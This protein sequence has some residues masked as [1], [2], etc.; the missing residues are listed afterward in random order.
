M[1]FCY[2]AA[3]TAYG[4]SQARG[5]V[6]AVAD[7][8]C[9]SHCNASSEPHLHLHHSSQQRQILNP[10]SKARDQTHNLMIPSSD[11]FRF[12][13]MGTPRILNYVKILCGTV[14]TFRIFTSNNFRTSCQYLIFFFPFWAVFAA[15]GISQA[16]D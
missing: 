12:T 9:Q 14:I 5:L 7:G 11:S 1:S 10:L 4:G 6:R 13:T 15:Y 2:R 3:P 8:L 16:R